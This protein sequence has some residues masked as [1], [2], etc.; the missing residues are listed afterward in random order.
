[1]VTRTRPTRPSSPPGN[2]ADRAKRPEGPSHRRSF[3]DIGKVWRAFARR[4]PEIRSDI[5]WYAA[6]QRDRARSVVS[7]LVLQVA[8]GV[9]GLIA[10][11]TLFAIAASV[12]VAGAAGGVAALLGDRPWLGNLLTG[13]TMLAILCGGTILWF[14]SHRNERMRRLVRRY[15]RQGARTTQPNTAEVATPSGAP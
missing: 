11:S 15:E 13:I 1:M 6:V 9:L 8:I 2:G 7:R 14:R 10:V 4:I 5:G 3:A 12:A